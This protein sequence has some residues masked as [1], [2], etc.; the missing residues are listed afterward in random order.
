MTMMRREMEDIK[1]TQTKSLEMRNI[2]SE[3]KNILDGKR[4]Y[5]TLNK[6]RLVHSVT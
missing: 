5:Y 4:T 6:K 1:N 2:V 3:M